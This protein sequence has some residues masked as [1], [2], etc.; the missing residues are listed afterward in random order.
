[1]RNEYEKCFG[2]SSQFAYRHDF[3]DMRVHLHLTTVAQPNLIKVA[4]INHECQSTDW[5]DP[6]LSGNLPND[7]RPLRC[8]GQTAQRTNEPL[9]ARL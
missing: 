8:N 5:G 6:V 9:E 7:N 4:P 1:M 2:Y 3:Q